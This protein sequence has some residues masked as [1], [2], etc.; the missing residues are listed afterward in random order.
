MDY[1]PTLNFF[2]VF[3]FQL[4]EGSAE[5]ILDEPYTMVLSQETAHKFFGDEDPIGKFIEIDTLGAYEVK[6]VVAK[7]KQKSHIQFEALV[8]LSTLEILDQRRDEPQI[9]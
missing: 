1:I 2:E 4:E 3:D 7:A 9:C 5:G 8:S 6:G